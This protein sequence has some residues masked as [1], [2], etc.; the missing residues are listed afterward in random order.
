MELVAAA[1][2]WGD[3]RAVEVQVVGVVTTVPRSGPIV[4]VGIT[5]VDRRTIHA[6][7][8]DEV[9]W[10]SPK[11]SACTSRT[12]IYSSVQGIVFAT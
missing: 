8:I 9:G 5:A 6:P 3:V 10:V 4:P 12:G 2:G 11:T 1:R 7:G